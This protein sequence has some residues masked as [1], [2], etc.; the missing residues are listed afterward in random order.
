MLEEEEE[1]EEEE[2]VEV[3]VGVGVELFVGVGVGQ[4]HDPAPSKNVLSYS[5]VHGEP[6]TVHPVTHL[7]VVVVQLELTW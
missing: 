2:D 5:A 7:H 1:E 3:G 4:E 6:T